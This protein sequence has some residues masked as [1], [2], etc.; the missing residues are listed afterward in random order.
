MHRQADDDSTFSNKKTYM[1]MSLDFLY[2]YV[3]TFF[4]SIPVSGKAQ[5]QC[6]VSLIVWD[7]RLLG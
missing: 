2:L 6:K 4:K 3:V 7:K 5:T 1:Q